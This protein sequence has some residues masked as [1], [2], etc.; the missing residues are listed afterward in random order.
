[1]QNRVSCSSEL[2][3]H[4]LEEEVLLNPPQ[5]DGDLKLNLVTLVLRRR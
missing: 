4:L 3:L 5:L 2:D 1:M